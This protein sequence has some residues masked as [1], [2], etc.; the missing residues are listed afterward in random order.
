MGLALLLML[1]TFVAYKGQL[2]PPVDPFLDIF[3][4]PPP[5]NPSQSVPDPNIALP[6]PHAH[7]AYKDKVDA[8]LDEQ[9]IFIRDREIQRFFICW[10]GHP[11]SNST[12]I[13][14]VELQQLDPDLLKLY[15]SQ[16]DLDIP[17]TSSCSHKRVNVDESPRP[18]VTQV[19]DR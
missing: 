5:P 8:M 6:L 11:D 18:L 10:Q 4:V 19:Y 14:Q 9:I 16:Q 15:Q 13:T 7:Y 12:W 2:T 3:T 1:R 17:A